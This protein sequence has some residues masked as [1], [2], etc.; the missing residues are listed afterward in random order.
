MGPCVHVSISM[1]IFEHI[2]QK[3]MLKTTYIL[4]QQ[5]CFIDIE[6]MIFVDYIYQS[7]KWFK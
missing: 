7:C 4:I 3:Q 2:L 5:H 1:T 6:N